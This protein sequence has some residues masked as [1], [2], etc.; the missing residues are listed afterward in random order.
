MLEQ[1]LA[2]VGEIEGLMRSSVGAGA[3][4]PLTDLEPA[5]AARIP[6]ELLDALEVRQGVGWDGDEAGKG[7]GVAGRGGGQPVVSGR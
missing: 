1:S 4:T 3:D 6:Q 5:A 7:N 2:L